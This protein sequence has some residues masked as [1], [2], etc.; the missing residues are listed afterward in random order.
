MIL[1]RGAAQQSGTNP[2]LWPGLFPVISDLRDATVDDGHYVNP[3]L[4]QQGEALEAGES[5]FSFGEP[6]PEPTIRLFPNP[7]VDFFSVANEKNTVINRIVV[8]NMTGRQ[9]K[10]Y[11]GDDAGSYYVGDLP[12]GLY[13]IS[14]VNNQEGVIKTL[15]LFKRSLRP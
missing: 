12:D 15:R 14:L 7:A 4:Y 1:N 9:V 11:D 5:G 8:M 13:L 10:Q 2:V 3:N 6:A